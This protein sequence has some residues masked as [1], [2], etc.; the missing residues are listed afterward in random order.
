MLL[1]HWNGVVER[2]EIVRG[3]RGSLYGS[4]AIGGVIHIFTRSSP[5]PYARVG[6]GSY[7]T[8]DFE[9][10]WGYR[11]QRSQLSVNA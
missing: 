5:D 7:G 1:I 2:V 8:T 11:G 10:G 9:G 3:P 4:D 6:G